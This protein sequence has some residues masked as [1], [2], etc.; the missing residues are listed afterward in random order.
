MNKATSI[1]RIDPIRARLATANR[2]AKSQ[3]SIPTF[4]LS[5]LVVAEALVHAAQAARRSLTA[6][7]L[8]LIA[9]WLTRFPDLNAHYRDGELQRCPQ[10]DLGIAL[11]HAE[12]VLVVPTFCG[13]QEWN[14][15]RFTTELAGLRERSR[16]NAFSTGDFALASFTISNLGMFDIDAFTSIINPPQVGILSVA[17][18]TA[19]PIVWEGTLVI[20]Q[21]LSLTLGID[22]RALDGAYSARTLTD[23][24][25][26]IEQFDG[27]L[28]RGGKEESA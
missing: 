16:R 22:H 14:T 13:C 26:A 21:T 8:P 1:V 6:Q 23:L 2:M 20:R 7:L 19:R 18:L 5:K 25:A 15:A 28:E 4:H 27:D 3:A 12:Q 24:T 10:V 9:T 17:A 11:A